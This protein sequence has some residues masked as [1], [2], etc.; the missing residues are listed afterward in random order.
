MYFILLCLSSA[1]I[2][3]DIPRLKGL[4]SEAAISLA[5]GL[6]CLFY[7]P[8]RW[9]VFDVI[10]DHF[11]PDSANNRIALMA[12]ADCHFLCLNASFEN[13]LSLI[14]LEH[15]CLFVCFETTCNLNSLRITLKSSCLKVLK[16]QGR[17]TVPTS[18]GAENPGCLDLLTKPHPQLLDYF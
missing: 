12:L 16:L 9:Q 8:V 14:M 2:A 10:R 5:S 4:L 11:I 3:Q 18:C 1:R 13:R 15:F 7:T 17:T 6:S